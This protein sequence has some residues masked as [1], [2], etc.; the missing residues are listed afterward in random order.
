MT[1]MAS[2]IPDRIKRPTIGDVARV[3]GLSKTT[4]SKVMNVAPE[5]I[6]VP[7]ST[8]QR[9][10]AACKELAYQPSWRAR[11]LRQ[12]RTHV[13]AFIHRDPIPMIS[14]AWHRLAGRLNQVSKDRGYQLQL[15]SAPADADGW[16]QMLG[17]QRFDGC[18]IFQDVG[19]LA[20]DVL[21]ESALPTVFVNAYGSKYPS[22]LPDDRQGGYL[23]TRHLIDLGHRGIAFVLGDG[24]D[25]SH[26]HFSVRHRIEGYRRAL[27]ESGLTA[28]D[29]IEV[30]SFEAAA[31]IAKLPTKPT[32]VVAYNA[33]VAIPFLHGCWE[34]GIRVPADLSVGTFNDVLATRHSI[35]PLTT[36][37]VPAAEVAE[38]ASA[39]LLQQ[40][41]SR[42]ASPRDATGRPE[43][44]LLPER[45]VVRE[46]TRALDAP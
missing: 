19:E 6:D 1:Q 5:I 14:D 43:M 25:A 18:F 22:V 10:L 46:S 23:L 34:Q 32:A 36:I 11:A 28:E 21:Q 42:G 12:G 33:N 3:C 35:P 40:I 24:V 17:E 26:R 15:V 13:L 30:H 20:E 4:V 16:R 45:L 9:V 37:D 27:E 29:P 38:R 2:K 8:R 44:I 31:V 7:E 39:L 41:E